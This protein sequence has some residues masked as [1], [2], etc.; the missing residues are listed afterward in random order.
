MMLPNVFTISESEL[1][2][3]TRLTLLY[4][5]LRS[6]EVAA[7]N[8]QQPEARIQLC[9]CR[10]SSASVVALPRRPIQRLVYSKAIDGSRG[11]WSMYDFELSIKIN[12]SC[13]L[14]GNLLRRLKIES[15]NQLVER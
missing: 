8:R 6:T 13:I 2:R 14:N 7:V 12:S 15:Q 3:P 1:T 4:G 10:T 5:V 9:F 11:A